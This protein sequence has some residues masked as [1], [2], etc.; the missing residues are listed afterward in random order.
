MLLSW[1]EPTLMAFAGEKTA[2]GLKP[3]NHKA[4]GL[5]CSAP[6]GAQDGHS[7]A[8]GRGW[9]YSPKRG[10]GLALRWNQ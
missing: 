9:G 4:R 3:S 5:L 1:W 7:F 6:Q 8:S 10:L 2:L